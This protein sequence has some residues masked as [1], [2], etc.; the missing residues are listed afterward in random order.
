MLDFYFR[1]HR[2]S[3]NTLIL[4]QRYSPRQRLEAVM[5]HHCFK[6]ITAGDKCDNDNHTAGSEVKLYMI[7]ATFVLQSQNKVIGCERQTLKTLLFRI[8]AS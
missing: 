6:S 1:V 4:S 2:G 3:F 8:T 7:S 5:R